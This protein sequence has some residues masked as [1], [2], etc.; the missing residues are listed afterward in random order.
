MEGKA[1]GEVE[2]DEAGGQLRGF[3]GF[4]ESA[5]SIRCP[6]NLTRLSCH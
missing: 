4:E 5:D 6:V 1:I 2:G 3:S